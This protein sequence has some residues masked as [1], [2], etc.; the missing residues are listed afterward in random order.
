[1]KKLM[2]ILLLSLSLL[3][4][5]ACNTKKDASTTK[6]KET[7]VSTTIKKKKESS[8]KAAESKQSSSSQSIQT[9]E[10]SPTEQPSQ[11]QQQ[12]QTPE[13]A[14]VD[15]NQSNQTPQTPAVEQPAQNAE[16]PVVN[17]WMTPDQRNDM[18]MGGK[19]DPA[20]VDSLSQSDYQIA[21]DRAQQRLEESGYG[22]VTLVW[23]EIYKMYPESTTLFDNNT[24]TE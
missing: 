6:S 13:A 24:P 14:Y 5:S 15:P 10:T 7:T 23:H 9:P 20:F 19:F 22:D 18:I 21:A 1:M 12:V 17:N 16:T 11:N 4:L 2:T 8:T 3:S